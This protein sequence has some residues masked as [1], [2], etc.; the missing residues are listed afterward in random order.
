[1]QTWHL[2]PPSGARHDVQTSL[3]GLIGTVGSDAFA[4]TALGHVNR[5][6]HAGS[7]AVYRVWKDKAPVLHLSSAHGLRD[8]TRD[9]FAA[10]LDG[11]YRRDRTFDIAQAGTTL[12]RLSA[13]DIPNPEHREAI[14][15]RHGVS[16][17]LSIAEPQPDGGVLA[18][19]LYHHEHQGAFADGELENFEQLA[20]GLLATVRRHLELTE[21]ATPPRPD[22]LQLRAALQRRHPEMPARELDVCARLLQGLSYDGIAADLG[23]SVATVKT[24]RRRAFERMG[25]HFK[26]ELFAAFVRQV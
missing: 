1:M 16:E 25:L 15:K 18:V 3:A 19:N 13:H 4:Q 24:Y 23:L 11:L 10:Y 9:C 26:S 14:Y 6:L 21:A 17:R 8:T 20:V 5:A 2:A 7:W 12:L 22:A